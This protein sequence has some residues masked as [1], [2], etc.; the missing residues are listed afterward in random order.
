MGHQVE[1]PLPS[2]IW[3]ESLIAELNQSV[4]VFEMSPIATTIERRVVRWMCD[5]VGYG[6]AAA[7]TMTTGGTKATFTA[8]LAARAVAIPDAWE[9]GVGP[10]P[11][12]LV[13]SEHAHYA[14]TRPPGE[15]GLCVNKIV[16][17][18]SDGFRMSPRALRVALAKANA[19]ERTV[20]PV[21]ATARSTPTGTLDDL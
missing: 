17:L 4:A 9:N 11:P 21:S 18:A 19:E 8:F 20:L 13:C 2:A 15:L 12:I 14:V 6:S 5:L 16:A 10:S 1:A 7:G 3:S